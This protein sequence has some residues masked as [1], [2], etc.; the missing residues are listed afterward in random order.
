MSATQRSQIVADKRKYVLELDSIRRKIKEL[1]DRH[2]ATAGILDNSALTSVGGGPSGAP[3][4]VP[5]YGMMG[6]ADVAPYAVG[7]PPPMAHQHPVSMDPAP[8]P[9]Y[10][11]GNMSRQIGRE[12]GRSFMQPAGANFIPEPEPKPKELPHHSPPSEPSPS[13][14]AAPRRSH[15][16]TIKDPK[17]QQPITEAAASA[18]GLNPAS[19]VYEPGQPFPLTR[20]SP[21]HF[22]VPTPTPIETPNPPPAELANHWAFNEREHA[23][24]QQKDG[25]QGRMNGGD[26]ANSAEYG[27]GIGS[28]EKDG[29]EYENDATVTVSLFF[30]YFL[31]AWYLAITTLGFQSRSLPPLD[32]KRQLFHP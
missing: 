26:N 30:V 17:T 27:A 5:V 9:P 24:R 4:A 2:K 21:P 32:I 28:M 12:V 3:F 10:Q 18:Q 13:S 15:A 6:S 1:E 19:P 14:R 25:Q 11:F 23:E 16:I 31:G 29:H 7:I 8:F 20:A 22:D